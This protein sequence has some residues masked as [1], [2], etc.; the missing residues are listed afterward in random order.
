MF[1]IELTESNLEKN[2]FDKKNKNDNFSEKQIYSIINQILDA[3]IYLKS[4]NI[5]HFDIKPSNIKV[6]D[7]RYILGNFDSF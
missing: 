1:K 2:I 6:I 3:L 4:Q 5:F 7:N